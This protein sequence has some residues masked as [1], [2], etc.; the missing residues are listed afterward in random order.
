MPTFSGVVRKAFRAGMYEAQ[1]VL[2]ACDDVDLIQLKATASLDTKTKWVGRVVYRDLTRRAVTLNPGLEPVRLTKDYDLFVLLCSTWWPDVWYAN[3]IEGWRERC[4]TTVC[5]IDELWARDVRE[6]KRWLPILNQFDYVF[7]GV[8]GTAAILSDVLGR[9]CHEMQGGVDA[10]RFTPYPGCPRR[11]IDLYSIGRA[12]R[13]IH[14]RLLKWAEDEGRFYVYDSIVNIADRDTLDYVHHRKLYASM[15][16]RSRLFSVAPGKMDS[17][18]ETAGQVALGLRFFEGSASG[19][20][21]VGQAPDCNAYRRHFDWQDAVVPMR[22]DGADAVDVI[23]GLLAQPD[24]LLTM[25][26]RNAAQALRRHDWVYRWKEILSLAG[27]TPRP[28]MA[29]RE[30]RLSELAELAMRDVR[31]E[32]PTEVLSGP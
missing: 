11:A 19:A 18:A 22:P 6:L 20:V 14:E 23:S 21:L 12:L 25:S 32:M 13:P 1:D 31:Q 8:S 5:W 16:K 7:I 3:A 17:T 15:A 30:R 26:R 9:P 10:L 2:A 27:L 4:K 28:E 29:A 24:R